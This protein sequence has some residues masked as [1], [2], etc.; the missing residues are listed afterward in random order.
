MEL[1]TWLRTQWDRAGAVALALL[2]LLALG[3][4]WLGASDTPHLAIQIPYFISGG[5]TGI[6]LVGS[7]AALW[8]S[9]DMRDEWREL[10]RLR[11]LLEEER[12]ERLAASNGM[13]AAPGVRESADRSELSVG[14]SR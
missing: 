11:V 1:L 6:F 9:A 4:G 2:G 3:L 8:L 10:R 13:T 5:L 12:A 14:R 7:A